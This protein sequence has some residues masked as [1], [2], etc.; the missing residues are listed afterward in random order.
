MQHL[1]FI[2]PGRLEWWDVLEPHLE[3][4]GKA[5]VRPVAVATCDLDAEIIAGWT[6]FAR[7]FAF[8]NEVVFVRF[9]CFYTRSYASWRMPHSISPSL[10]EVSTSSRS[11][12]SSCSI[13]RA[14]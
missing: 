2:K 3:R 4:V 10:V 14:A 5:L 13:M 8:D 11:S 9:S 12:S 7:P 1:T 6:P